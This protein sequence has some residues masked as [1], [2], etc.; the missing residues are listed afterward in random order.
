MNYKLRQQILERDQKK[1]QVCGDGDY[2]LTIHHKIPIKFGGSNLPTNLITICKTC[3]LP[4]EKLQIGGAMTYKLKTLNM[5]KKDLFLRLFNLGI[6][7]KDNPHQKHFFD[8]SPYWDKVKERF[9]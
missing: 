4:I 3:H 9:F 7:T 5:T 2:T 1:C 6:L 8:D